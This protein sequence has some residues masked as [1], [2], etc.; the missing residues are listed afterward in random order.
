MTK[1]RDRF[2][3]MTTWAA[4]AALA[5]FALSAAAHVYVFNFRPQEPF[6]LDGLVVP[7][8]LQ[9][10]GPART[11]FLRAWEADALRA[12]VTVASFALLIGALGAFRLRRRRK[13]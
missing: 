4:Y 8:T 13:P 6:P 1:S 2:D 5:L 9:M 7:Q 11:V 12:L 10:F 3:A